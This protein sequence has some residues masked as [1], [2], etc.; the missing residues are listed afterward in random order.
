L[1]EAKPKNPWEAPI[2]GQAVG[3]DDIDLEIVL[4]AGDVTFKTTI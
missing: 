4:F 3:N 2:S 1:R